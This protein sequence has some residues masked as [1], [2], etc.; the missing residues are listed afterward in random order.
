P[1]TDLP[2]WTDT[3]SGAWFRL[4]AGEAYGRTSPVRTHSPLFCLHAELPA[5]AE[6]QLPATYS[7]Q[8]V[9]PAHGAI[10]FAG[11]VY[12]PGQLLVFDGSADTLCA[13]EDATLLIFGG[14]SLGQRHIFWNF[15]SSRK[16]R[17]EQAADD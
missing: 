12:T 6:L 14:E 7:E 16:E 2:S 8:A 5:G 17:I 3:D 4:V 15:V 10:E 11:Q 9:Y 1:K 13:S